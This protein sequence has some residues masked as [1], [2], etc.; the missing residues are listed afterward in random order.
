MPRRK[1]GRPPMR[2]SERLAR[3]ILVR[4]S[5]QQ[6]AQLRRAA[7]REPVSTYVRRAAL[8]AADRASKE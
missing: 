5:E 8:R 1:P 7:G 2:S 3:T 4:V 6:L